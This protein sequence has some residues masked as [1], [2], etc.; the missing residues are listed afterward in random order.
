MLNAKKIDH[1]QTGSSL[2][3]ILVTMVILAFGLLGLAGFQ[4]RTQTAEMEAFQRAQ[5]LV[6]MADMVERLTANRANA[7]SYVT[8]GALGTGDGEPSSCT[9]LTDVVLRDRCEWSNALKGS[10]EQSGSGN[11]GAMI[12]A[13]GCITQI[14]APNAAAGVC[15]PGSYRVDVAWQGFNAT[16]ASAITCGQNAYGAD[17]L[18][19]VVSSSV[20]VALVTCS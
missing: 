14:Q 15:T 8:S 19:R 20:T 16:Q 17:T 5:A 13:R 3:E 4:L 9:S 10:S 1:W 18:R 6:L 11:V 7:A 12:G 2:I